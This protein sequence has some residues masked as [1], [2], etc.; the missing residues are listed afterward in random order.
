MIWAEF[1][2]IVTRPAKLVSGYASILICTLSPIPIL[3]TSVS[4]TCTFARM[5]DRSAMVISR[6]LSRLKVPWTA[7]SPTSTGSRTTRPLIGA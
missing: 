1:E 5:V 2:I 4:S 7:T 3:I 6:A